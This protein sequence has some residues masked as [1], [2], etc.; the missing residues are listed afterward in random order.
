MRGLPPKILDCFS[1]TYFVGQPCLPVVLSLSYSA[2]TKRAP[3]VIAPMFLFLIFFSGQTVYAFSVCG[4]LHR[5]DFFRRL[6]G[7]LSYEGVY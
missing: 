3:R 5:F 2:A 6:A 7:R 1:V 4:S